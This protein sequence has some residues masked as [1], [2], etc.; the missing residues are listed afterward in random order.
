MPRRGRPLPRPG[1]GPLRAWWLDGPA[2]P[3]S[4]LR[5]PALP[6]RPALA[7]RPPAACQGVPGR[8]PVR[9]GL[10]RPARASSALS[11]RAGCPAAAWRRQDVRRVRRPDGRRA[12]V[13]P[14]P[15]S[16]LPELALQLPALQ[17]RRVLALLLRAVCRGVR[18]ER[19][20][21]AR[22]SA[23]CAR[24]LRRAAAWPDVAVLPREAVGS[25]SDVRAQ[26]PAAVASQAWRVRQRAAVQV[27][28]SRP[29]ARAVQ[30]QAAGWP[31]ARPA[32]QAVR[33]PRAAPDAARRPVAASV[34]RVRLP[35]VRAARE[36]EAESASRVPRLAAVP[37]AERLPAAVLADAVR[38]RAEP[39]A[40]ER[41]ARAAASAFHPVRFL[42]SAAPVRRPAAKFGRATLRWR[43]ASPS[44]QS[45]QAARDEALS[46]LEVP[47]GKSGQEGNVR[48]PNNSAGR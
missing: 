32:V 17:V 16:E 45:W 36:P 23:A 2:D 48:E 4:G 9:S 7:S 11:R 3:V 38:R 25:A 40:R 47:G 28:A 35:A 39:D 5:L 13:R 43:T 15:L 42:P 37:D 22:A 12:G 29:A 33:E 34:L 1:S 6:V 10:R 41:L 26:P 19:R 14:V 20:H 27:P 30:V 18:P 44:A 46:C 31:G 21:P 24:G 8:H